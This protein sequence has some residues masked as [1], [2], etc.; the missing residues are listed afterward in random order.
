MLLFKVNFV[1]MDSVKPYLE[2]KILGSSSLP[3]PTKL[4]RAYL[5]SKTKLG[6]L[7]TYK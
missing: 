6:S 5:I 7:S 3:A 1:Y 2:S 4:S